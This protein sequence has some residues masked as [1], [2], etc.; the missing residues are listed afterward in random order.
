VT[1]GDP[2]CANPPPS[3]LH[4]LPSFRHP[5]PSFLPPSTRP[6]SSNPPLTSYP[7]GARG[8]RSSQGHDPSRRQD[9]H[10][11]RGFHHQGLR[12]GRLRR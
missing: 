11:G 8:S 6:R 5:L 1:L 9:A 3:R 10:R 7:K 12:S 2:V 4:S